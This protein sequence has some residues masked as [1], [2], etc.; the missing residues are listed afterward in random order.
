MAGDGFVDAVVDHLLD[1]VI[2]AGR[3]GVHPGSFPDRL[4]S[5]QDFNVGG[6]VACAQNETSS[7]E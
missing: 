2:R 4:Q 6:I 3:V 5:R 7:E 1:Q